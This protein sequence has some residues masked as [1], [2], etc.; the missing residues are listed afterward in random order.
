MFNILIF[1]VPK[2]LREKDF[3]KAQG[4]KCFFLILNQGKRYMLAKNFDIF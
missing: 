2:K 4:K 1:F 3:E